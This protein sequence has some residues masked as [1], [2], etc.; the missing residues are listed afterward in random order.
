MIDESG[1]TEILAPREDLVDQEAEALRD[2]GGRTRA[3][4]EPEK[5]EQVVGVQFHRWGEGTRSPQTASLSWRV[6]GDAR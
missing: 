2:R 1:L 5:N 4:P 3:I 6:V